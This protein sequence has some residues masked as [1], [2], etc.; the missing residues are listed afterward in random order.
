MHVT[1]DPNDPNTVYVMNVDFHKSVDGGR[2]FNKIDVPHGDNHGLWIDPKDSNRMLAVNDGGAT[3]TSDGGKTWSTLLNQPTAQMYHVSADNRFPYYLYG[4]QQD[5]TSLAIAT[6]GDLGSID[7]SEWYPVA[8]GEAGY[9]VPDPR[10]PLITYGGEYQGQ[11]SR[12]DKHTGQWRSIGVQPIISDALGAAPLEHRFQWTAPIAISPH[13]PSVL[14]HGGERIFKTTDGGTTWTAISP[15][16]TRNDKSKQQV[17]GGPITKDDTGTEYYD[18]V[19]AIAE[20]PVQKD[21]IWAGT[22]DGLVQLT[23]DGGKSWTNVTPK[24]LPEWSKISQIDP[25][26]HDAGTAYVAVDRHLL[27]D[28]TPYAYKT[29]DFGRTWTKIVGGIPEGK[30]VRAVREDPKR[31]GLLYAATEGGVFISYNDGASWESFQLN[32]PTVPVHDLIVKND[33]L[34]LAT[35]GRGFWVLDGLGPARQHNDAIRNGAFHLFAPTVAYRVRPAGKPKKPVLTGENPPAGAIIYYWLKSKPKDVSIEILDSKGQRVRYITDKDV[36]DLDE[37]PDPEDEKP[38]KKIE[39]KPDMNRFVWDMKYEAVPRLKDYYL[40]AYQ[41]GTEGPMALPG[42]YTVKLTVDGQSQAQ[43]LELAMDPRVKTP[44]ADLEKQLALQLQI[45]QELMRVYD[46]VAQ[47]R[48]VR[49][50]LKSMGERLPKAPALNPVLAARTDLEGK[51]EGV[52][53]QFIQTKIRANEDSLQFPVKLDG[54]LSGLASYVGGADAVPTEAAYKRFTQ[55]K[56]DVDQ[57][58]E[59]WNRIVSTDLVAFQRLAAQQNVQAIIVPQMPGAR[60]NGTS[61]PAKK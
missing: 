17:S 40:Y 10:D 11:I 54:Q 49:E 41:G 55:L 2:T 37:Q 47:I 31:K 52:L 29:N 39:P 13:D 36:D 19:F 6:A 61:S 38:K 34:V 59:A 27:D 56:A 46:N 43:P 4:G 5:N 22:D 16:L 14:Y 12:H 57:Q 24:D 9:I 21:L 18:T 3:A 32:L 44:I 25:S 15:D 53:E 7:R 45:R 30:F 35:H 50:Q 51:V 1:A 28:Y 8:G 58:V 23:R 42:K 20:S 33:D 60:E 48:D 26:P